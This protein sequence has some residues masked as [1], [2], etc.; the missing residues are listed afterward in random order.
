MGIVDKVKS[1]LLGVAL[2]KAIKRMAYIIAAWVAAKGAVMAGAGTEVSIDPDKLAVALY[3]L[4][5]VGRNWLKI[6]FPSKF[7]WL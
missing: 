6:K 4:W 2:K 3:G 1:W 5:E 7:G